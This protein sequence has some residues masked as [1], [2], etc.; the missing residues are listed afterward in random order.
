[1]S[2]LPLL[3]EP[4][5][6]EAALGTPNLL[7]LDCSAADHYARFHV[8]GAIHVP[9]QGLQSGAPPAP[10]KLPSLP[11]LQRLFGQIGLTA[12]QHVVVYDDEGG[13]WAGRLLWTLDVLGFR[14][15]S[16]LNGGLHAWVNEGHPTEVTP[17]YGTPVAFDAQ[18]HPESQATAEQIMVR[19]GQADFAVW[20]ARSREEHIGLRS[21]A[22]RP[23]RI[24]GAI[25]I[26]WLELMDRQRNLRFVDL[27]K[28][29]QRL[30]AL[31][32]TKD[33]QIV[34][35]CQTHHRSGLTWLAMKV[36]GYPRAQAY[37][38]SWGEWGNRT[39]TPVEAG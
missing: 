36:L 37:D 5:Q 19:L 35:H 29:Q 7:I 18:L 27:D 28:L 33:K 15:Y 3:L 31:G 11:A 12:D 32:L 9:P 22:A 16:Y 1:M 10:G 34:T 25:N 14:R 2:D 6:L 13:G 24:P 17:N 23:G 30:D 21:G 26:D 38:G 4:A 8:P 39:D 20:D